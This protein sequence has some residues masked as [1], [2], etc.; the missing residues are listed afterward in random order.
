[1]GSELSH[2]LQWLATSG[3]RILRSDTMLPVLL[4]GLN[5]SG[6]EY[7][8]P[9]DGGFLAAA[10]IT[11]EE[12]GRMV[13]NWGAN[14]IRVPFNQDWALRGRNGRSAE[15]YRAALDQV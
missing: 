2:D 4:R 3:P 12:I 9:N 7:S 11:E 8:E 10:A 13:S 15:E 6:L 1:M 14:I 5:R